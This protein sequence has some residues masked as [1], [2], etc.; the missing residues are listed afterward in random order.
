M[1]ALALRDGRPLYAFGTRGAEAQAQTQLQLVI[2]L[3]DFGLEPQAAIEAPRWTHG[4]QVAHLAPDAL[5]VEGRVPAT[6][7]AELRARGHNVF[8]LDDL[9]DALGTAQ[10]IQVDQERGLLVGAADPRGDSAAIGW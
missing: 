5:A 1:P 10:L 4:G 2:G 9:D 6:V 7:V 8:V 3:V